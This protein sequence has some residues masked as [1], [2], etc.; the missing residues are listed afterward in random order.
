MWGESASVR[1]T[2]SFLKR[3]TLKEQKHGE[4]HSS[5]YEIVERT[6]VDWPNQDAVP[7]PLE[8]GEYARAKGIRAARVAD[9]RDRLPG[10]GTE[11]D[12]ARGSGSECSRDV[13]YQTC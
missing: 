1:K 11:R 7:R 2:A 4:E 6:Y 5:E 10:C 9:M 13:A 8:E 12:G 3:S